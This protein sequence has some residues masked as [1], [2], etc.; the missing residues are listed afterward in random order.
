MLRR[1]NMIVVF[2]NVFGKEAIVKEIMD[3]ISHQQTSVNSIKH[4]SLKRPFS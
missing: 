4:G 2:W 3:F 1:A